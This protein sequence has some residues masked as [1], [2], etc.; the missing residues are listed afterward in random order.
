AVLIIVQDSDSAG[1]REATRLA[2]GQRRVSA[3]VL[4]GFSTNGASPNALSDL[5]KAG[6]RVVECGPGEAAQALAV[7]SDRQINHAAEPEA[8]A[9]S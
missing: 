3:I 5:V 2:S 6:A 9:V 7:L 4:T 1:L 8:A